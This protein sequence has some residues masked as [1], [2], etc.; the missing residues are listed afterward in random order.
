MKKYKT[1]RVGGFYIE[2]SYTLRRK[3]KEK[4]ERSNK[5][6]AVF[7]AIIAVIVRKTP[8]FV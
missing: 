2:F 1:H 4:R 6:S 8:F 3:E 7:T 5:K